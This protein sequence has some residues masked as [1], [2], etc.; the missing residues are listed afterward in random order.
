MGHLK[1]L[2]QSGFEIKSDED[3]ILV[4]P[5]LDENPKAPINSEDIK[6]ADLVCVTHDHMDHLGDSIEICKQTGATFVGIFELSKYAE[7]EGVENS[8]GMNIG[9]TLEIEGID[10]SMVRAFHSSERGAPTGFIL[11]LGDTKIYHAG[12]TS[13]FGDM[14]LFGNFYQPEIACLPIGGYYTMGPRE[15][16][17]AAKLI[18]PE[19]VIPMHFMTFPVL[20]QSAENFLN[21]LKKIAPQIEPIVLNP[22]ETHK[23]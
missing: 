16:A 2:G 8:V 3:T 17:E 19:Y 23:F 18:D 15:A 21:Q 22:G 10:I 5:F 20:E 14:E 11:N 6:D 7:S 4:D 9:A 12:D 13:L 1:W